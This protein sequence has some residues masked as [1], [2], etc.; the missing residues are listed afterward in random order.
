MEKTLNLVLDRETKNTRRYAEA[1]KAADDKTRHVLYFQKSL[2]GATA[3]QTLT[4]TVK[5][6]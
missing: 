5:A 2:L 4:V 6:S 1:G 3:S